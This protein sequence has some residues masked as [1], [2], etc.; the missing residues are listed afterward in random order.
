MDKCEEVLSLRNTEIKQLDF[1]LLYS[2]TEVWSF[3]V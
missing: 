3:I 2:A 1:I